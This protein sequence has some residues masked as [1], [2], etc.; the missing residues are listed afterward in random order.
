MEKLR[1]ILT[2]LLLTLTLISAQAT[3]YYFSTTDGDD[4]RSNEQAQNSATPWKT[5]S[6]LNSIFGTLKPGDAVLFKRGDVFQ[7]TIVIA[8]NGAAELPITLSAYGTGAKPVIT[9][10]TTLTGW[11]AIGNGLYESPIT[12]NISMMNMV[13]RNGVFQPMGRWP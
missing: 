6:K 4:S 7:G 9:G 11:K 2:L 8:T 10:F 3:T 5:I 12:E 1:R 13:V